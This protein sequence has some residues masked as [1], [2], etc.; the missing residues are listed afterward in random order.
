MVTEPQ[1]HTENT[2][3]ISKWMALFMDD[4]GRDDVISID[5][6]PGFTGFLHNRLLQDHFETELL[7]NYLKNMTLKIC[8]STT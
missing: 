3:T 6:A 2:I 7:E 5:S 4:E 1:G 8:D